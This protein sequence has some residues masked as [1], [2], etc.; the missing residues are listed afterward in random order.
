MRRYAAMY[1]EI[2]RTGKYKGKAVESTGLKKIGGDSKW[3]WHWAEQKLFETF[4]ELRKFGIPL[5]GP[6]LTGFC[7]IDEPNPQRHS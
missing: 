6:Y 1:R 2:K 5:N 4:S 7:Q 3:D